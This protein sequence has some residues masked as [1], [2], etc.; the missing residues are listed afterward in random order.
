MNEKRRPW[1]IL[2]VD[3]EK[4]ILSLWVWQVQTGQSHQLAPGI[5][6]EGTLHGWTADEKAAIL[7]MLDRISR[8]R[9]VSLVDVV[10]GQT[11]SFPLPEGSQIVGWIG[12]AYTIAG[13][14]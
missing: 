10:T 2:L 13:F 1:R 5:S 6:S 12:N 14:D 11:T 4:A 8:K 7:E 9:V 3:D